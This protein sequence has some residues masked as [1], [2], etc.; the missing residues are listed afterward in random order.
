MMNVVIDGIVYSNV[1]ILSIQRSFDIRQRTD[2]GYSTTTGTRISN[3]IGTFFTY[4]VVFDMK[5][6]NVDERSKLYEVLSDPDE[7]H[8]FELPYNDTVYKFNGCISSGRDNL[9]RIRNGVNIWG[10]LAVKIEPYGK[11]K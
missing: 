10:Q 4:D 8:T 1:G 6:Y 7:Y 3:P 5:K 2:N 9:D 11:K